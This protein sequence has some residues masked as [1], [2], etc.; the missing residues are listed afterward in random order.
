MYKVD[1]WDPD[2]QGSLELLWAMEQLVAE[3]VFRSGSS[4]FRSTSPKPL[5]QITQLSL[6]IKHLA[7]CQ[8]YNNSTTNDYYRERNQNDTLL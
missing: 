5:L 8:G 3:L 6:K 4:N 7:P 2:S 1:R